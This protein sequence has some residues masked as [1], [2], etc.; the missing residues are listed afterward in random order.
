M[1][2]VY[3]KDESPNEPFLVLDED[4]ENYILGLRDYPDV[5]QDEWTP[6]DDVV[7]L[8]DGTKEYKKALKI[9]KKRLE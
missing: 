2:L 9:I 4:D 3:Y 7:E 8:V 1:K 6:K 5:E